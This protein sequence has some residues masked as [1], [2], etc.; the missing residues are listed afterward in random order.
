MFGWDNGAHVYCM[1]LCNCIEWNGESRKLRGETTVCC[2]QTDSFRI[3]WRSR[4]RN[5]KR[6]HFEKF[7]VIVNLPWKHA[8]SILLHSTAHMRPF[9][10]FIFMILYFAFN[11]CPPRRSIVRLVSVRHLWPI[12]LC[13]YVVGNCWDP[14]GMWC[15]AIPRNDSCRS[16]AIAAYWLWCSSMACLRIQSRDLPNRW[17]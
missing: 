14:A 15:R 5:Y 16:T 11:C 8:R 12:E 9:R 13:W 3:D 17:P 4:G 1:C 10:Y 6:L 7:E 2:E